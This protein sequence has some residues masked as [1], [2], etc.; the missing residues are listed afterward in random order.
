MGTN[1]RTDGQ[2]FTQYLGISSHSMGARIGNPSGPHTLELYWYIFQ[3]LLNRGC[4]SFMYLRQPG[5]G[6]L[7]SFAQRN[8]LHSSVG[9]S[10]F[11]VVSTDFSLAYQFY[12]NG[13]S[14]MLASNFRLLALRI[15]NGHIFCHNSQ[16]SLQ[17][18]Y[19]HHSYYCKTTSWCPSLPPR[20]C[21]SSKT[22]R[23]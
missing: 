13:S 14:K 1:A 16:I 10:Y 7:H 3:I 9:F 22:K 20:L 17:S 2:I 12:A 11:L 8:Y 6:S 21:F 15:V 5:K 23:T 19:S 4:E 18:I